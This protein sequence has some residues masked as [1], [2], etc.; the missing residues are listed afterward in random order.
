MRI[1]KTDKTMLMSVIIL[2]GIVLIFSVQT[3]LA[4][5]I[6]STSQETVCCE[7]TTSKLFCQNV[8]SQECAPNKRQVP[9][10]CET[11]SY[12]KQGWCFDS[13]EGTC[14]DNTPQLV[15]NAEGG[16]WSE[17]QPP[18][19]SLGCCVLGDQAA[20][21]TLTRCKALSSDLG[22]NTNFRGDIR[23]ETQCV[24]SVAGQ[25]KGACVFDFE[26]ERTCKFT[27]RAECDAGVSTSG[28]VGTKTLKGEF[29]VG[30]LCSAE[31]L[32]TNCGLTRETRTVAGKDEVYWK[33]SCGNPGNIY[34][35]GKVDDKEYWSNIKSKNESCY[36]DK[37]N[38]NSATCG[39]CNY[40]L[41]SFARPVES[42]AGS[43]QPR[44]GDFICANLNCKSTTAGTKKHG[45]SWCINEDAGSVDSAGNSVGSRFFRHLCINGEEV[46]ESCADFRQETCIEDEIE[47]SLG[48]FSQAACRVN[49]W[50]DC[51]VQDNK[52]DCENTDRRECLWQ[53]GDFDLQTLNK[54][55]KGV[56]VPSNSPGFKFW[57]G[58]EASNICA[59]A[60]AQC[61]VTFEKGLFGGEECSDNCECLSES[62]E[63]QHA[64]LCSDLGDCGPNINWIGQ[65]GFKEGY[66]VTTG[67]VKEK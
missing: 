61:V 6:V 42:G 23:D 33:D 58:Q 47:T 18:Q 14:S 46:V 37:D 25:E 64:D 39:N 38:A 17:E 9:T 32:G 41:G 63:K 67:K 54:T 5:E 55:Q 21:V 13:S 66:E 62:W 60:N 40:L 65:K 20:F 11:T 50:Q 52:V 10:S 53:E 49:R 4:A 19:C 34:D 27:T 51:F 24:L 7:Q 16:F 35:S 3:T 26:F 31:E 57:E 30:K 28:V 29:F 44:Y 45:E 43:T 1:R 15:C 8:P 2:F 56:C 36:P 59:Q 12:C 48:T 22:L